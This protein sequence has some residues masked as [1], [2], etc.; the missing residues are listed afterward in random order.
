[1]EDSPSPIRVKL[2]EK[3]KDQERRRASSPSALNA[4]RPRASTSALSPSNS[5]NKSNPLYHSSTGGTGLRRPQSRQSG[6]SSA[7]TGSSIPTPASRPSTPTFLPVPTGGLYAHSS[8]AGATGLK[9]STGSGGSTI[10]QKRSSTG[11]NIFVRDRP[12]T[13][14]PP[15][16]LSTESAVSISSS[17]SN[18]SLNDRDN[19]KALPQIPLAHSNVTM[20]PPSKLP[21]SFLSQSRIGRPSGGGTSS[22]RRGSDASSGRRSSDLL[23]VD[24]GYAD[25]DKEE[26]GRPR[27]GS[28]ISPF[29]FGKSRS[30]K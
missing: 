14:P 13:M 27:S 20:R 12:T 16:R 11:S 5:N 28:I 23:T 1:M 30:G 7:T 15:P 17:A 19:D 4:F 10:Q 29:G 26:K 22:G 8:T 24:S 6:A 2:T 3:E 9:R 18:S 25:E 21:A